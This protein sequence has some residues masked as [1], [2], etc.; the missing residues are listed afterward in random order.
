MA[1]YL[2]Y[3]ELID[4]AL[5]HYTVGGDSIYECWDEKVFNEYV[6]DFGK[7]TK[8]KALEMFKLQYEADQ[9]HFEAARH[10]S[11]EY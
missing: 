4:L 5:K 3:K 6:K 8:T 7:I 1:K 11:G 10:F 9:E 2:T